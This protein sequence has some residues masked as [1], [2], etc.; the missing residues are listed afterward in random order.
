MALEVILFLFVKVSVFFLELCF[1]LY[2]NLLGAAFGYRLNRE[3]NVVRRI[4]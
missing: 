4:V 2:N 3:F 1:F